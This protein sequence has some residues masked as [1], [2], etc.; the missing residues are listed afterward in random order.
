M[1]KVKILVVGGTGYLGQHLL[2]AYAHANA[3]GTPFAFDLAFTHHSSPPPRLLLDAIP[4][5]LPFQVDFK[6]GS[7][8]EAISNTFGQPDVVVNCAAISVPRAC[9]IDPDN[10]HAI[11]V[12][13]SLVKWLQSF[14]KNRTLLIHLSTDQVYEG[15]KSFYKEEDNAVPVNVYG[16]TKVAA[17][18]FI[19]ENF[20]N[21]A[22][23]RSSIIYGPQTVS[24]VAKSLPIQVLVQYVDYVL[25]TLLAN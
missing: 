10:A 24:P 20:P 21:F 14:E 15:E 6:T 22:I 9:E 4:S 3:N 19:S 8:F 25:S 5:S 1:S 13:S 23:L 11:N 2:Q 16:K 7:G 18:E 12:P 17:E